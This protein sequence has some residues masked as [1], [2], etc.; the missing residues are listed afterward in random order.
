MKKNSVRNKLVLYVNKLKKNLNVPGKKKKRKKKRLELSLQIWYQVANTTDFYFLSCL[1][2]HV[3]RGKRQELH[4]VLSWKWAIQIISL[5]FLVDVHSDLHIQERLN[6][7]EHQIHVLIRIYRTIQH[8]CLRL[9]Y[10]W[11]IH[12]LGLPYQLI[13]WKNLPTMQKSQVRS[14]GRED[15]LEKGMATHSSI[16]AW[17]IPWT[18]KPGRVQSMGS[19]RVNIRTSDL[20]CVIRKKAYFWEQFPE[21][22]F[23]KD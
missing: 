12:L 14:L 4:S 15:A 3:L 9:L 20:P 17:R 16:L 7:N 21:N 19:Q 8:T 10:L 5:S 11:L 1:F 22:L 23:G 18:E 6:F 13:W 2:E